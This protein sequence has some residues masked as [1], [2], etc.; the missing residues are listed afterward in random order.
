[1]LLERKLESKLV[2]KR[3]LREHVSPYKGKVIVALLFMVLSALCAATI[4]WLVQPAIDKVFMTHDREMLLL[5]PLAILAAHTIKG[6]AEYFQSYII[7]YIGQQIL[8]NMQMR[9]YE[10][11]LSADFLFLQSQSSGRLISRFTNDIV[12]MRGAVSNMLVG[13]AKHFLSVLF[14]IIKCL[15]LNRFYLHLYFSPFH[16]QFIQYKN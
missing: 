7:K 6:I 3:L 8:T 4:V 16:S 12:L 11:L 9:M 10:H 13:C 14:L 15:A 1:M 5:I 2:I